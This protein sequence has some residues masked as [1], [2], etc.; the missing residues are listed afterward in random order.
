MTSRISVLTICLTA[1]AGIF[2]VDRLTPIGVAVGIGYVLVVMVAMWSPSAYDLLAIAGVSVLL[3]IAGIFISPM[4]E[5]SVGTMFAADAT[6]QMMTNRFLTVLAIGATTLLATRRRSVEQAVA[7]LNETLETRVNERTAKLEE[8]TEQLKQANRSYE[9]EARHRQRITEELEQIENRYLALVESLPLNVFQKDIHGKITFGNK[10]YCESLGRSFEDLKGKTDFDLFPEELAQKYVD[11]DEFVMKSG[12]PLE[13]IE[14]HKADGESSTYVQVL[15]APICDPQGNVV[16]IQGM[17]WDVTRRIEAEK[18]QH[19]ADLRFRRLVESDLMG[20]FTATLDGEIIEPNNA[21]LKMLGYT[22]EEFETDRD[23]IR[24]DEITPI[25][26]R[27]ADEI[28]I[29]QLKES[30]VAQ[31]WEKEYYTRY[32]TRV[33]VLLGVSMVDEENECICFALD[34]SDRIES[35]RLLEQAKMAADAASSAKSLF[36]ANMSHEVR[37]PMNAIIGMTELVLDSDLGKQQREYLRMVLEAGESLL[38][39]INHVLDLTR[40]EAGRMELDEEPFDIREV[41]GDLLKTLA[42]RAHAKGLELTSHFGCDVPETLIGDE[43]RLRQI[44]TN[45]VGNAIKFTD[46]GEINFEVNLRSRTVVENGDGGESESVQLYF[47]VRDTG[48]GIPE[49]MSAAIFF[50]FEQVDNDHTRAH[51]GTGLGLAIAASFVQLMG[52][53][54]GV[55]S[56]EGQG[57]RFH[58]SA[59]FRL[60][61][62]PEFSP[63]DEKLVSGYRVLIVDDNESSGKLLAEMIGNWRMTPEVVDSSARA[64]ESI[65]SANGKAHDLVLVDERMPKQSGYALAE[66]LKSEENWRGRIVMML[67]ASEQSNSIDEVDSSGIAAFVMKPIKQSELFDAIVFALGLGENQPSVERKIMQLPKI[68]PLNILLAEDSLVNQK[69]AVALLRKHGHEVHIANNGQ[70]A[71]AAV[72]KNCFDLVLMDVQMPECDGLTATTRIREYER[73]ID[74]HTPIMAMTAHAMQGDRERCLEAGMDEYVSKPIRAALLFDKIAALVKTQPVKGM[75]DIERAD[76]SNDEAVAD[77]AATSGDE[78]SPI[79]WQA[80]LEATAGSEEILR[81]VADGFLEE[82]PRQL[83]NLKKS[84]AESDYTLI[85]RS[86]HTLKGSLRLFGCEEAQQ[87]ASTIEEMGKNENI[88]GVENELQPLMKQLAG[89]EERIRLYVNDGKQT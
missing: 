37:T 2:I 71:I 81:D 28:A 32:G 89:I 43:V 57:S 85:R 24:W 48:P 72:R 31:P 73:T 27:E 29:A 50:P 49:N 69:L 10:R 16:G 86:A 63:G 4:P 66:R 6:F 60:T 83:E 30:G 1:L 54:I 52:G 46:E 39:I 67:S 56:D 78:V 68:Q 21:F 45:L 35:E 59:N 13:D 58:F 15:K 20:V 70:E 7:D 9:E 55:D 42:V 38:S 8:Q 75:S 14:E 88:E 77:T 76:D 5:H 33:S 64:L 84:L 65:Q 41:L 51:G 47:S 40:V 18:Q 25:E 19:R 61:D 26:H 53:T 22:R 23:I 44:V 62:A 17:F 3:V 36:L 74:R 87:H 79:N 11:D 80:A 34:I 12:T 82:C